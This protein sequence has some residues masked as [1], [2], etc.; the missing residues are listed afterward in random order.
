[1][2]AV[3]VVTPVGVIGARP[4]VFIGVTP[5]GVIG[6]APTGA[7]RGGLAL[8]GIGVLSEGA[9]TEEEVETNGSKSDPDAFNG[10]TAAEGPRSTRRASAGVTEGAG[11]MSDKEALAGAMVEVA[12]DDGVLDIG[13]STKIGAGC[14]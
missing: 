13:R 7:L 14:S 8:E 10:A 11:D 5:V 3:T 6:V 9:L 4:V 2:G 12:P 1:M